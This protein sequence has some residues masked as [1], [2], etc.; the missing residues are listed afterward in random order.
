[1]AEVGISVV[2]HGFTIV[3]PVTASNISLAKGLAA[4]SARDI[5]GDVDDHRCL[6][7]LCTCRADA[8]A[9]AAKALAEVEVGVGEL[10]EEV[11]KESSTIL[12]TTPIE[13]TGSSL[14]PDD[15]TEEGFAYN[16]RRALE[17]FVPPTE[18]AAVLRRDD[19]LEPG[20]ILEMD[21]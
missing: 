21:E 4:E 6:Q 17:Q 19:D 14:V 11:P 9:A 12:E 2:V 18:V 16:A 15:E 7:R 1:M 13:P 3:S 20:E 8:I 5:L 10:I